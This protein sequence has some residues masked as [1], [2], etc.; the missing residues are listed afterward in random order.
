M[1][2]LIPSE[3]KNTGQCYLSKAQVNQVLSKNKI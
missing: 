3:N 2:P 1:T